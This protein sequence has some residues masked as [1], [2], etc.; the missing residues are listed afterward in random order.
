MISFNFDA[1]GVSART[2]IVKI[3]TYLLTLDTERWLSFL[4]CD[5]PSSGI[6]I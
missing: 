6:T 1:S 2:I 4:V 3:Y 5:F